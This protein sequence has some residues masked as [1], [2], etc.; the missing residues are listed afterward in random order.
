[1]E[2]IVY[3]KDCSCLLN[4]NFKRHILYGNVG[5]FRILKDFKGRLHVAL[6]ISITMWSL[7]LVRNTKKQEVNAGREIYKLP[8]KSCFIIR[9]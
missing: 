6:C 7:Y 9:E 4:A 5:I 1:M 2:D 3:S 8:D